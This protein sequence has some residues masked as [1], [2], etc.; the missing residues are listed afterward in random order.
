MKGCWCWAKPTS[1]FLKGLLA[2]LGWH[3][4]QLGRTDTYRR[5]TLKKTE[6]KTKQNKTKWLFSTG[7]IKIFIID[8]ITPVEHPGSFQPFFSSR[9]SQC[10]RKPGKKDSR[11]WLPPKLPAQGIPRLFLSGTLIRTV[12]T[13]FLSMEE[14]KTFFLRS[15]FYDPFYEYRISSKNSRGRLL[16]IFL[17]KEGDYSRDGYYSRKYGCD[18]HTGYM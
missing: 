17:S 7:M 1:I 5:Q 13:R 10:E 9:R 3:L 12:N 6:E 8:I 14:C 2:G 11:F 18:P 15:H 4:R 16:S